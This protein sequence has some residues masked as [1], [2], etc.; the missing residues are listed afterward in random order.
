MSESALHNVIATTSHMCAQVGQVAAQRP[1][2]DFGH[3]LSNGRFLSRFYASFQPGSAEQCW[4]FRDG[5]SV[6]HRTITTYVDGQH[7]SVG[8]HRVALAL[9]LGRWPAGHALHLC[10][11]QACVNPSHLIEGTHAENMRHKADRGQNHDQRKERER[12]ATRHPSYV[13]AV[14]KAAARVE[15]AMRRVN[16]ARKAV[17]A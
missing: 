9:K 12:S 13:A 3:L 8:A 15:R 6:A 4:L 16:R 11:V 2:A 5:S 7:V 1:C 14:A 17:A 10:D